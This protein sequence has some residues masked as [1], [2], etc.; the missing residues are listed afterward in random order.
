MR[1]LVEKLLEKYK[2]EEIAYKLGISSSTVFKWKS[3]VTQPS[4]MAQEK[5]KKL[6]GGTK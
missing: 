3:H 4:P 1:P 2:V 5:I 6:L